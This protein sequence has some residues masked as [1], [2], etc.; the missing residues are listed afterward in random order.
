MQDTTPS[1]SPSDIVLDPAILPKNSK[2]FDNWPHAKPLPTP[3]QIRSSTFDSTFQI[4]HHRGHGA[5]AQRVLYIPDLGLVIKHGPHT[6]IAEGQTLWALRKYCPQVRVP[7]VYG[8]FQD[9]DETFIYLSYIDGVSLDSR[10]KTLSDTELKEVAGQLAPMIASIR[11]LRQPHQDTFIG[12]LRC[13]MPDISYIS[14]PHSGSPNR[15]PIRDQMWWSG[16][17]PPPTAPFLS[18]KAFNDALFALA[19]FLPMF[20]DHEYYQAFRSSFSDT[21]SIRFTHTDLASSN[22]II[23]RTSTEVLGIIDWQ[24]SG[25]YPEYWEYLKAKHTAP[26]RWYDYVDIALQPYVRELEAFQNYD[27]TGIFI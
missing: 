18:V 10:L 25:W 20:P 13:L 8:W 24:E 14:H 16:Y 4:L 6:T 9:G 5:Y 15:G 27:R 23:S 11:H 2:T 21:S 1:L 3:A 7:T 26:P 12:G 17:K 22:I 19:E